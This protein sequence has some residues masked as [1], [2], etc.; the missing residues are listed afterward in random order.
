MSPR[1]LLA[2]L[3]KCCRLF[4]DL[5]VRTLTLRH[6]PVRPAE[7]PLWPSCCIWNASRAVAGCRPRVTACSVSASIGRS[8]PCSFAAALPLALH[9]RISTGITVCRTAPSDQELQGVG[10]GTEAT[11]AVDL[12]RERCPALLLQT[13]AVCPHCVEELPWV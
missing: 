9:R 12:P 3:T 13:P 4:G 1:G 8:L 11:T 7:P 6:L 2:A 5:A 10:R